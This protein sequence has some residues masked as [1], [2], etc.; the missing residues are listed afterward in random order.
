[1]H[2]AHDATV[3]TRDKIASKVKDTRKKFRKAL[4]SGRMSGGGRTVAAFYYAC[5]DIWSGSPATS[6]LDNGLEWSL[7]SPDELSVNVDGG[8]DSSDDGSVNTESDKS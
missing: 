5:S 7:V 6:I 3:F 4:D 2:L 8:A 1:M